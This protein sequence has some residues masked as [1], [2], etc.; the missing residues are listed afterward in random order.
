LSLVPQGEPTHE[1]TTDPDTSKLRLSATAT[2]AGS[3]A[4][5]EWPIDAPPAEL[6]KP[7]CSKAC[8][9]VL[10]RGAPRT[11]Q[12]PLLE[13]LASLRRVLREQPAEIVVQ[14]RRDAPSAKVGGHT[15]S[16]RL[17]PEVI[18]RIVRQN[19]EE[20]RKCYEQGLAR[21]ANLQGTVRV[22]FV[23]DREGHVPKVS[24]DGSDLPD[25]AVRDCIFSAFQ[26]FVFP[27]P[28][29]GIVTV[30][31]PIVLVPG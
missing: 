31:Y 30:V 25:Q 8:V 6:S 12:P 23:I 20:L 7:L 1:L 21:D 11:G 22:R 18:Q 14:S 9:I 27:K 17:P 24:D 16:G 5:L 15:V 4:K 2:D 13:V 19:F 10:P 26:L 29:D 28:Q 3:W